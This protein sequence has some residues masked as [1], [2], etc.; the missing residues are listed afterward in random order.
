MPLL[1]FAAE[2]LSGLLRGRKGVQGLTGMCW[3]GLVRVYGTKPTVFL[4]GTLLGTPNTKR[5]EYSRN[6]IE[7]KDPGRYSPRR[8]PLYS[9]AS[10]FGVPS[11][12]PGI[13]AEAL[14]P[15]EPD[16]EVFWEPFR[17]SCLF[18]GGQGLLRVPTLNN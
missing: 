13:V 16:H 11:K 10:L 15:V 2:R 3:S 4:Q 8:F 12:V 14:S 1:R 7:H 5:Q 18:G 6:I 9:W 17:I